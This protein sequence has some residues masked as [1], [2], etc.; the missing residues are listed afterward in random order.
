MELKSAAPM[1]RLLPLG[2][3][4]RTSARPVWYMA[5]LAPVRTLLR[6]IDAMES[7]W[8]K[9]KIMFLLEASIYT[10]STV[11]AKEP[12]EN[13]NCQTKTR[14]LRMNPNQFYLLRAKPQAERMDERIEELRQAWATSGRQVFLCL[15]QQL[16]RGQKTHWLMN[17]TTWRVYNPEQSRWQV[18][19]G[20][21][22]LG[23]AKPPTCPPTF[24]RTWS[25]QP[26]SPAVQQHSFS[27]LFI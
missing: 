14:F 8:S 11:N 19:S 12:R 24:L 25:T 17:K 1:C 13:W 15:W 2:G 20:K 3:C 27:L 10:F 22:Q 23:V 5:M 9:D 7:L 6:H 18:S 16:V 4:C 21:F 26:T